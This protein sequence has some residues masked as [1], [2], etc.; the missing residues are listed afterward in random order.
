[1]SE[2]NSFIGAKQMDFIDELIKVQRLNAMKWFDEF[3][4]TSV[5]T[6]IFPSEKSNPNYWVF[7]VFSKNVNQAIDEFKKKGYNATSVHI[8]NNIY[9]VFKN[10]VNLRGV[11]E[12]KQKFVAIPSGWWFKK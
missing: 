6:P 5:Y 1:M 10:K 9:S 11:N 2:V 7:G 4:S 8:N 3:Q 12:F